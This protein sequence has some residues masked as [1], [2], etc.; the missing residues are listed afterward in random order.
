MSNANIKMNEKDN[1]ND[2]I[3]LGKDLSTEEKRILVANLCGEFSIANYPED[4]NAI[5]EAEKLLSW[6]E[7]RPSRFKE[8][9]IALYGVIDEET[10][11]EVFD[12]DHGVLDWIGLEV[13]DY[14]EVSGVLI[15]ATAA[16][17]FEALGRV[18]KLW[19]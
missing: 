17:K 19:K 18:L 10:K 3:V 11:E 4:L 7:N 13:L 12:E 8:Y 15:H 1:E 6:T 9:A 2:E 5:H 14:V 16:Q